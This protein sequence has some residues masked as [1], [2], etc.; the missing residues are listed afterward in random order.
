MDGRNVYYFKSV[1]NM[2]KAV[3]Q[4]IP[5]LYHMYKLRGN[6]TSFDIFKATG[7]SMEGNLGSAEVWTSLVNAWDKFP[8]DVLP[9]VAGIW[10]QLQ[11][12]RSKLIFQ[13]QHSTIEEIVYSTMTAIHGFNFVRLAHS[14]TEGIPR[15]HSNSNAPPPIRSYCQP[16]GQLKINVD[17]LVQSDRTDIEV[18]VQESDG[19]IL[20]ALA[21]RLPRSALVLAI[22]AH[23]V[24]QGIQLASQY[25]TEIVTIK[26]DRQYACR[27]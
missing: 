13:Q 24:L 20:Q 9:K 12:A 5:V 14:H 15:S 11:K 16:L 26:M 19:T 6:S 25:G 3:L 10:W 27:Q 21:Q 2:I 7:L 22:E 1:G 18:V 8:L 17:T 23:G 4:A